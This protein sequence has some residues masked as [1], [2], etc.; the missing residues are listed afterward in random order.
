MH[1]LIYGCGGLLSELRIDCDMTENCVARRVKKTIN[2]FNIIF[3][4]FIDS[5]FWRKPHRF[6][7]GH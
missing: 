4:N 7:G 1:K 3:K 6:G 2:L 5:Y